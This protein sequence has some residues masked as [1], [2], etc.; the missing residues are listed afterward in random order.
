MTEISLGILAV[1]ALIICAIDCFF[2]MWG[3][4]SG[5]WKRR[6]IGS[7]IQTLGLNILSVIGGTWAWQYILSL[8]PEIGSRSMGYGGDSTGEKVLRRSVFAIGSLLVGVVLAWGAGF[9]SKTVILLICQAIASIITIILG[10]KNPFPAAV[11]EVFVCFTLKYLNY[12]YI[13]LGM[14]G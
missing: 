10:V 3:G 5:K 7:F 8:G 9:S 12:G 1:V 13:F 14:G 6:Y 4:R 11:E 2:W